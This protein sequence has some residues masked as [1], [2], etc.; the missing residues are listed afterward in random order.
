VVERSFF[1]YVRRGGPHTAINLTNITYAVLDGV[2]CTQQS[3][4]IKA[5]SSVRSLLVRDCEYGR[6][7]SQARQLRLEDGAN[8]PY[9][10]VSNR[11]AEVIPPKS[12]T[13]VRFDSRIEDTER[14]HDASAPSRITIAR[15]GVYRLA[16]T[17][18][19]AER[20]GGRRAARLVRSRTETLAEDV[21]NGDSVP[22]TAVTLNVGATLRLKEGDFLELEVFQDTDGE[23]PTVA[24][25][26]LTTRLTVLWERG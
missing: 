19:L 16:A 17:T 6:L 12:W 9:C 1:G 8:E 3:N 25:G 5:D 10:L 15:P 7:D 24:E 23:L 2:R 11:T 4:V 20:Q 14:M 22:G 26:H 21:R 18:S 13:P